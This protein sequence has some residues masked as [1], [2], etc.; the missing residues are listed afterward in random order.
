MATDWFSVL[1]K[2]PWS[3]LIHNA[4]KAAES[5]R[6]LWGSV[7]RDAPLA[8][9]AAAQPGDAPQPGEAATPG[10]TVLALQRRINALEAADDALQTRMQAASA[11]IA[12]LTEQHARL[13]ER[14]ESQ[15][16]RLWV[17]AGMAGLALA[18]AGA[19]LALVVS[20]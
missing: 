20:R 16:R 15:R 1:R 12:R 17:L 5:A 13:V 8:D 3:D 14:A 7:G 6:K 9:A 4:P 11:L 2:V 10:I 18:L 19:A